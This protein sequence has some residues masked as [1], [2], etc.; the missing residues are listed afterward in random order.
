M[1]L[2]G[3]NLS[4]ET[5]IIAEIG[6]NHEG[7]LDAA[8]NLIRL[9]AEAGADAVKF[10]SYTPER[11]IAT[12]DAERLERVRRFGLDEAS[13]RRLAEA[14]AEAGIA[15]FS[16][17]V[18]EDWV[19]KLDPLVGAFKVASGDLDFRPTIEAAAAT[20]KPVVISTGI[21]TEAEID[22]AVSW[23]AETIG[24]APLSERLVLMHC[25]SA[26]P[27]PIEEANLLSIP[28]LSERYGVPV[29]YSNH[30]IGLEAPLAAV[31]LGAQLLEVHFTD[32]SEGRTF[33]DHSLSLEPAG[34]AELVR[35]V[36][37]IRSSR[38]RFGKTPGP[39]EVPL[40]EA[41]R[42]GLV[43]ARQLPAGHVLGP[44]DLAYA[45]PATGFPAT[46]LPSILGRRLAAALEPG[47]RL[48]PDQLD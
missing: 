14:A 30:V 2:F 34:L 11:F 46:A 47:Q 16:T 8:L 48:T 33:R 31:A 17:P 23:V 29:G 4:R 13:H 44:G 36:P 28:F 24:D 20:G 7:S 6:V 26:Y 25:V 37:A 41:T 15:F 40:R 3:K 18:T 22:Q 35:R 10:Q 42:K 5:A 19:P 39:S 45:R 43:A 1:H 12:E 32:K 38:G 21:G 9:A 27:A